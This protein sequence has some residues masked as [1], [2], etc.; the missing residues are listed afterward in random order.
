MK[1]KKKYLTLIIFLVVSIL[2]FLLIHPNRNI[3]HEHGHLYAMQAVFQGH[4][5]VIYE[6]AELRDPIE[7]IRGT[8]SMTICPTVRKSETTWNQ[9]FISYTS[10][11]GLEFLLAFVL[12]LSPF[13]FAGG[14]WMLAIA[15]SLLFLNSTS[16]AD[17]AWMPY[18]TKI[19]ISTMLF[20][21]FMISILIQKHYIRKIFSEKL[22]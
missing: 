14:I 5:C 7:G 19:V 13:S 3:I 1:I 4:K 17:L 20:L 8:G 18:W 11:F 9:R 6:S 21:L 16:H 10:G 22:K 2:Y 12:L 15:K